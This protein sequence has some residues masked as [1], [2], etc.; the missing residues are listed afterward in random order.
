MTTYL[1][2]YSEYM[3]S[4][5]GSQ[6]TR[7]ELLVTFSIVRFLGGCGT[8]KTNKQTNKNVILHAVG[9]VPKHRTPIM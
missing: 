1:M 2:E 6:C 5:G 8:E 4:N 7:T 9:C 3:E